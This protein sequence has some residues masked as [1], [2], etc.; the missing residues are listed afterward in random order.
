MEVSTPIPSTR[1]T[2]S[3]YPSRL[4]FG[5]ARGLL[6]TRAFIIL[7]Q[8]LSLPKGQLIYI[9]LISRIVAMASCLAVSR[10]PIGT[11]N[12]FLFNLTKVMQ[13]ANSARSDRLASRRR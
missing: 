4:A 6:A 2:L 9:C 7:E 3:I 8:A 13:D 5:Y 12:C 10:L 11:L 1:L